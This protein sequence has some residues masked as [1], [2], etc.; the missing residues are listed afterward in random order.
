M[1]G[2]R[3]AAFGGAAVVGGVA[4]VVSF[5]HLRAVALAAGE[6][7]LAATLLPVSVDGLLVSAAGVMVADRQAGRR[8]RTSAR[9]SF[10]AGCAAT[11]GGN[12][13]SAAPTPLGWAVASWAPLALLLV[14]EMLV[15][16]GRP[17]KRPAESDSKPRSRPVPTPRKAGGRTPRG[18]G[19]D[20]VR[21]AMAASPEASVAALARAAGVSR[22]TVRRVNGHQAA[23]PSQR[24]ET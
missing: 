3:L 2:T 13:A 1:N 16:H 12:L 4:A 8:A 24:R 10:A 15:R 7:H 14:T 18:E 22:S 17:E 11:V 9:V 19:A 6:G 20:R 23:T 21:A 5:G